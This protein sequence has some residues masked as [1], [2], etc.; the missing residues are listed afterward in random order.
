[1]LFMDIRV[2]ICP[3]FIFY[4]SSRLGYILT[5]IKDI[6]WSG[7]FISLERCDIK[8]FDGEATALENVEYPFT[9]IA[10]RSTLIRSGSTRR[11]PING[12]NCVQMFS[13]R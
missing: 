9:F 7:G 12:T 5:Y 11:V 2:Y 8:P 4:S 13:D 3:G 10:S 6:H 1:M